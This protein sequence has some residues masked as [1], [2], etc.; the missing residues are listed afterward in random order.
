VGRPKR[1]E[2][3]PRLAEHRQR[4][5]LTQA[6]VAERLQNLAVEHGDGPLPTTAETI[7]RHE[8]GKHFPAPV[9]RRQYVRLFGASEEHLGLVLLGRDVHP[10]VVTASGSQD[11][12]TLESPLDIAERLQE[13]TGTNTS[14]ASLD[15]LDAMIDLFVDEY[16]AAGPATL[17][18]R[19]VRQRRKVDAL[20]SGRQLP[21]QRE[22]LYRTASR[23]SGLLGYMAVNLGRFSIAKA[24][25]TEAF[26]LAEVV[27]DFDLQAW[28]R[29]TESL[30]AYYANDYKTAARLAQDGQRYARGGPQAVRLA[31]NGEARA[32]ARLGDHNGVNEAVERAYRTASR[33]TPVP[34]VSSCISFG[35]YSNARTA[36]NAATAY[37]ALGL[38]DR[39]TAYAN[40]V[41]PVFEASESRWSQSLVRIDIATALVVADRPDPEQAAR[42]V[43]EAL[44]LSAERP[45]TSVISRSREFLQAAEGWATVPE[46][47]QAAEALRVAERR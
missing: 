44:M 21:H 18:P 46:V 28:T 24:Y 20:L 1:G 4:L 39:V 38:P 9:Y 42:L 34:G 35:L 19:V 23:L 16:E 26:Q 12:D 8:R 47:E 11:A 41:L 25:C 3:Q 40:E 43:T 10:P 14:E 45:I 33:L 13:L 31:V 30:N 2:F 15:Q 27:H 36:S 29:G 32:L 17:A 6:Q 5:G 7:A 37:V 22:R